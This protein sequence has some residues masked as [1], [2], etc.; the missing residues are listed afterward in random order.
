MFIFYNEIYKS[1]KKRKLLQIKCK[2]FF[3]EKIKTDFNGFFLF[4]YP[5]LDWPRHDGYVDTLLF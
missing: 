5:L 3:K 1:I 2:A 4:Y